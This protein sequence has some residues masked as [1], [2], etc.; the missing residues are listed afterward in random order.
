VKNLKDA[1]Q[2]NETLV[3][4]WS[5]LGNH[6]A[7]EICANSGF[8]FILID[9]EHGA[10]DVLTVLQQLQVVAAYPVNPIVR[11][12]NKESS[13]I[14]RY[15]DIGA[16]SILAP[17]INTADDAQELV[18][19][20]RYPPKGIRGSGY[21]LGRVSK[22]GARS[23]YGEIAGSEITLIAQI[24]TTEALSNLESI[25]AVEG[26]DAVFFGPADIAASLGK[27]GQYAD[28]EVVELILQGMSK[29][30]AL[31]MPIGVYSA[32]A[33]LLKKYK[34]AGATI[35]G[36]ASDTGILAGGSRKQ[37]ADYA[38]LCGRP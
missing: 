24:E 7:I 28:Q 30:H 15:L 33:E 32:D 8:D 12:P 20:T 6:V 19:A 36:V 16:T 38:K 31:G 29:V 14:K 11:I 26:I 1:I 34:A 13:L 5:A 4:M 21:G 23:N 2:S 17:F 9:A 22:W 27:I 3:G 18:R 35:F 37:A 10:N 25:C